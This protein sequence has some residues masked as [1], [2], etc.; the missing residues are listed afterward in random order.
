MSMSNFDTVLSQQAAWT[1]QPSKRTPEGGVIMRSLPTRLEKLE[2]KLGDK[3]GDVCMV[4]IP[5]GDK[6]KDEE[7]LNKLREVSD[8]REE[9]LIIFDT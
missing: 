6:D 1:Q 4:F 8:R 7:E 9:L 5:T 3:G 2:E